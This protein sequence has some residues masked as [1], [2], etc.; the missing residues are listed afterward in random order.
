[1][2]RH[3]EIPNIKWVDLCAM[4]K[5]EPITIKGCMNFGLNSVKACQEQGLITVNEP[6]S[7]WCGGLDAMIKAWNIYN[8]SNNPVRDLKDVVEYNK[9][10]C[11]CLHALLEFVKTKM[12]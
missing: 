6:K 10:D 7:F 9:F 11:T 8:T 12:M 5:N 3:P 2:Q 1:M 4:F